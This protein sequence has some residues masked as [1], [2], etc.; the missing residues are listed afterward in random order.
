MQLGFVTHSSGFCFCCEKKLI[1]G[2]YQN[3]Y[4]PS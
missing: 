1:K 3:T 2:D 4:M